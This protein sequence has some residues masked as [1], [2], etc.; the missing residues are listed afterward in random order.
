MLPCC[1][2]PCINLQNVHQEMENI[3]S[4][5][6]K[7]FPRK[8]ICTKLQVRDIILE[9]KFFHNRWGVAEVNTGR[10]R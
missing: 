6:K 8:P 2:L 7:I 5:W 1:C 3:R 10:I 4:L 9:L